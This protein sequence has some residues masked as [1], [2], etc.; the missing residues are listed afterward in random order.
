MKIFIGSMKIPLVTHVSKK[1]I[2]TGLQIGF[3]VYENRGMS[4][5]A[6]VKA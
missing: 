4:L 3:D 2:R 5:K 6:V 1:G